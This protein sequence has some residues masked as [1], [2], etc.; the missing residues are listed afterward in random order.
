MDR[1]RRG[2]GI[3]FYVRSIAN[4]NSQVLLQHPQDIEFVLFSIVKYMLVLLVV[5]P[6]HL[7]LCWIFTFVLTRGMQFV[8]LGDFNVNVN[9]VSDPLLPNLRNL[10]D[11][12]SLVLYNYY[13]ECRMLDMCLESYIQ[14]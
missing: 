11:S 5:L 2:D 1:N 4:L 7:Q 3:A 13:G 8:L 10:L 9:D 14:Y 12:F 6:V